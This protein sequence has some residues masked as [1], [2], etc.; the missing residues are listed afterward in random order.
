M[1]VAKY[2]LLEKKNLCKNIGGQMQRMDDR[3]FGE[4]ISDLVAKFGGS[5]K[6]IFSGAI[7]I[8]IWM[9]LNSFHSFQ[10]DNYPYILLNLLLSLVA[11]FQAPFIMMS[12]RR[13]EIKQDLIYR[14]LFREIKDLIETDLAL[15]EVILQQN[16]TIAEQL[17]DLK[18][19]VAELQK[20]KQ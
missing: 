2:K 13:C 12:Q 20:Q 1:I 19:I 8:F 16:K 6:F 11:A 18:K 5:W 4:K 3:T 7:F 14:S 9:I 17:I 15:E 10:W